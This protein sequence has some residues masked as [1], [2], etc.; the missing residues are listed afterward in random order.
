MVTAL[1]HLR[2]PSGDTPRTT[3]LRSFHCFLS[4][5]F[6]EGGGHDGSSV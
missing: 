6:G 2:R 3:L 5:S 1:Q 4:V